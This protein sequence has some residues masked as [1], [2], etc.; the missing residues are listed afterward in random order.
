M[1]A[2]RWLR[3]RSHFQD[4]YRVRDWVILTKNAAALTCV[5]GHNGGGQCHVS[6]AVGREAMACE[7]KG[8]L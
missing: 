2:G 6:V 8:R 7:R 3:S 5:E 1:Q 4:C